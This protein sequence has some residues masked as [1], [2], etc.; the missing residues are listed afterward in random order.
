MTASL[1][2]ESVQP[3]LKY[4]GKRLI[5]SFLKLTLIRECHLVAKKALKPGSANQA[6]AQTL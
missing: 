3:G 2:N 5:L 4:R 1:R 6:P